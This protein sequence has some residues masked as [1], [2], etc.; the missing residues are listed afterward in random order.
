MI[1]R[2]ITNSADLALDII[3]TGGSNA[4]SYPIRKRGKF[5]S[6]KLL[7]RKGIGLRCSVF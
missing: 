7:H 2:V 4:S 1:S 6:Q 5:T 3:S